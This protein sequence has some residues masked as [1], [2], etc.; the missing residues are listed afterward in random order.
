M[1]NRRVRE[2]AEGEAVCVCGE[3]EVREDEECEGE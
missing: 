2:D 1:R 3:G